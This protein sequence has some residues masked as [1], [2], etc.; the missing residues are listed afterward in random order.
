MKT[1]TTTPQE[2][3]IDIMK[4]ENNSEPVFMLIAFHRIGVKINQKMKVNIPHAIGMVQAHFT[5]FSS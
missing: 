5:F 3:A 2:N 4:T 1:P